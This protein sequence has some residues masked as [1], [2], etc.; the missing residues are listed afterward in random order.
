MLTRAQYERLIY[1]L[2]PPLL[3]HSP[4]HA[5]PRASRPGRYPNDPTL[6]SA[7]PHY[8]HMSP[9]TSTGSVQRIERHRILAH[10]L[11]F[12]HPN[13]PFLIEEIEREVLRRP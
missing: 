11:S 8:K 3:F 5:G 13:L 6:A 9:D 7:H 4:Q 1:T 2:P 10:G 12:T